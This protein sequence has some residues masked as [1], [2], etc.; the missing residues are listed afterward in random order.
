[1]RKILS[2]LML[3][4]LQGLSPLQAAGVQVMGMDVQLPEGWKILRGEQTILYSPEGSA[5]VSVDRLGSG[6]NSPE[7]VAENMAAAV[8]LD[9]EKIGRDTKGNVTLSFVQN[10]EKI[11]VRA[12][13]RDGSVFM[14]YAFGDD[15]AGAVA[16]SV[17]AKAGEPSA[18]APAGTSRGKP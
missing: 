12:F 10:G 18:K 16:D 6:E 9:S 17:G 13:D 1:M 7:S 15:S 5:A 8:G 11:R 2:V 14:V 3:L 4:L